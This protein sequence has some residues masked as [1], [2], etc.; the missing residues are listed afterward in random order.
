MNAL[1]LVTLDLLVVFKL[2]RD[3]HSFTKVRYTENI[4]YLSGN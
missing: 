1:S 3:T 2:Y 4:Y